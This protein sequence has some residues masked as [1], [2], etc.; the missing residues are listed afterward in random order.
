MNLKSRLTIIE[1]AKESQEALLVTVWYGDKA[2]RHAYRKYH[3]INHDECIIVAVMMPSSRGVCHLPSGQIT[4]E[5]GGCFCV[6]SPHWETQSAVHLLIWRWGKKV[7]APTLKVRARGEFRS[8][9]VLFQ[10]ENSPRK[11]VK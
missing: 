1:L 10:M 11:N 3:N 7:M 8:S 5:A 6:V 4:K 9:S 2:Y